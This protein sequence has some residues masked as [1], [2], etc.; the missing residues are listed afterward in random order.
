ML[1][2]NVVKMQFSLGLKV[3]FSELRLTAPGCYM[4]AQYGRT[5]K[6]PHNKQSAKTFGEKSLEQLFCYKVHL[7]CSIY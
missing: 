6:Y 2:D 1:N 5:I 3:V 4:P 7:I